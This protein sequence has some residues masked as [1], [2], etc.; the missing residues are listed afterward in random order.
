MSDPRLGTFGGVAIALD[1]LLKV[2]VLSALIGDGTFPWEAVAA[3]AL[4]RMSILGLV[5]ALPYAGSEDGAGAWTTGID[6]WRAVAGLLLG[7]AIGGI[8]A[9]VK[10]L[11]MT[12]VAVV[13]CLVVGRWSTRRLAG[14]RGDTFGA[15]AELSETLALTAAVAAT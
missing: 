3:G 11:P 13:A 14:M 1:L 12:A 8:T 2:S 4:A 15:A 10:F 6:R 7:V 9:G 5:L